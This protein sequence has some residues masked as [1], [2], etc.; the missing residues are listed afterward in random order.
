[1]R[2]RKREKARESEREREM[3]MMMMMMMI[4]R[5]RAVAQSFSLHLPFCCLFFFPI[6]SSGGATFE[7]VDLSEEWADYDENA[8]ESVSIM[9]LETKIEV[10]K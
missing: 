7:D 1:M 5:T 6:V 10:T 8:G 3:M 2:E 4:L 9:E